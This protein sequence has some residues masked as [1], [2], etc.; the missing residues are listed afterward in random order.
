MNKEQFF[1]EMQKERPTDPDWQKFLINYLNDTPY[2]MCGY[3]E[4]SK[5][6]FF[7]EKEKDFFWGW[8]EKNMAGH[9]AC[10]SW[11]DSGNKV[12]WGFSNQRDLLIFK[13]RWA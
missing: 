13:L 5:R 12:W 8:I 11:S 10:I 4:Y 1:T 3:F 7:N 6:T 2:K 9:V